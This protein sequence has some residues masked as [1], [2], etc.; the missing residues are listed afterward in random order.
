MSKSLLLILSPNKFREFDWLRFELSLIEKEYNADIKIHDMTKVMFSDSK[1]AF[2]RALKDNRI[3]EYNSFKKWKED[4]R[5]I[6]KVHN[7]KLL[8]LN[9]VKIDSFFSF[10]VNF[11]LKKSK[12][13][14][15]EHSSKQHPEEESDNITVS[16]LIRKLFLCIRNPKL[17]KIH[18]RIHSG[19]KPY[20]CKECKK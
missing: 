4:F 6:L 2:P 12:V 3:A 5:K 1:K 16:I 15:I 14:V 10:L 9:F 7:S 18:L 19:E 11:E 17:L 13:K 8:V 20:S